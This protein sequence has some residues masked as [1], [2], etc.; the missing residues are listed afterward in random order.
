M[1][2]GRNCRFRSDVTCSRVPR[3]GAPTALGTEIDDVIYQSIGC[4]AEREYIALQTAIA[5]LDFTSSSCCSC[6][7]GRRSSRTYYLN[8]GIDIGGI[9]ICSGSSAKQAQASATSM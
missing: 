3:V 2:A 4:G 1:V 6:C 7:F 9:G 8:N 5:L